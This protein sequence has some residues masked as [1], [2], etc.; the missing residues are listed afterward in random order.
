MKEV[1]NGNFVKVKYT[2]TLQNGDVFDTS[3]DAHPLEVEVGAGS[4]IKGFEDAL[5]GM[6]Q[7]EKKTFTISHEE[8]YGARKDDL[9]QTFQRS[10]L[11]EGFDT[12]VGQVIINSDRKSFPG[13]VF[14]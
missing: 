8:A 13:I 1:G 9:E 11:P 7:N 6:A 4:V 14:P 5:M 12:Q 3:K 10:E 2:G